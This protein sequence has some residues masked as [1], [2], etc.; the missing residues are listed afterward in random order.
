MFKICEITIHDLL[1]GFP[2]GR[3]LKRRRII[4]LYS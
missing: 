3:D 2:E 1:E 4:L